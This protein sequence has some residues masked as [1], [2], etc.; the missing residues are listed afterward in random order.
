MQ[1]GLLTQATTQALPSPTDS[2]AITLES[3]QPT[4]CVA[5]VIS[6]YGVCVPEDG[7]WSE[8]QLSNVISSTSMHSL[9]SDQ[10][11]MSE[12]P[13]AVKGCCTPL[14][15]PGAQ[16]YGVQVPPPSVLTWKVSVST[17]SQSPA[18]QL[19]LST[20]EPDDVANVCRMPPCVV[21][22]LPWM[23]K[24]PEC[25]LYSDCAWQLPWGS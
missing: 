12:L 4:F 5:A 20:Y 9:A 25:P 6:V 11:I 3:G 16:V 18:K 10:M 17:P 8:E 24:V 1:A 21:P 7:E 14:H 19:N 13:P 22:Q 15:E 23:W 2:L